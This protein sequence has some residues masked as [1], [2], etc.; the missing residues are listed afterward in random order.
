MPEVCSSVPQLLGTYRY[1]HMLQ[2]LLSLCLYP[3]PVLP[4]I[5]THH[6]TL[7]M[8][9]IRPHTAHEVQ[10][11]PLVDSRRPR[12]SGCQGREKKKETII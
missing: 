10:Q 9:L 3:M 1:L 6:D 5:G 4:P 12:L 11:R 7:Q 8:T 2:K